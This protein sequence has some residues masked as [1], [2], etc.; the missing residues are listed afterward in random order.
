MRS[1]VVCVVWSIR[2]CL[3]EENEK[4]KKGAVDGR[5]IINYVRG[6]G[7]GWK[8]GTFAGETHEIEDWSEMDRDDARSIVFIRRNCECVW[9]KLRR[10]PSIPQITLAFKSVK[11]IMLGEREFRLRITYGD[12]L[13]EK[14][15]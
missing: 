13:S 11:F 5:A 15:V 4:G 14:V 7:N 6:K 2:V 1:V 12:V 9:Q 10:S 8:W 3:M